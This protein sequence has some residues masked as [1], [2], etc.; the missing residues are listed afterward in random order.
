MALMHWSP[1]RELLFIRDE[2]NRLFNEFLGRTEGQESAWWAGAWTPPVD[3]YDINGAFILKA[4]L[5]GFT[6]DDV[7]VEIKD[8]T[9][10]LKGQRK[11]EAGVKE[12]Q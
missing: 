1:A 9:L 6:K 11:H 7:S 2:M 12:E 5:P 3:I 8:N 4:E 10:T